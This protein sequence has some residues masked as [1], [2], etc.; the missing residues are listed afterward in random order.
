[1]S[2][3]LNSHCTA[4]LN[5]NKP[6]IVDLRAELIVKIKRYVVKLIEC[7]MRLKWRVYYV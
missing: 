1:M 7:G 2:C 3:C 5:K 4:Y 6:Y